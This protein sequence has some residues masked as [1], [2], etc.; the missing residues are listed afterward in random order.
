MSAG[1]TVGQTRDTSE[2]KTSQ[3]QPP[4]PAGE[5]GHY[6]TPGQLLTVG[7]ARSLSGGREAGVGVLVLRMPCLLQILRKNNE[8]FKD[9]FLGPPPSVA[10][11]LILPWELCLCLG[12]AGSCAR[13]TGREEESEA[14]KLPCP[15]SPQPSARGPDVQ[16]AWALAQPPPAHLRS[17]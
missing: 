6:Q 9:G 4:G 14:T 12:N 8:P 5:A 15:L 11:F 2:A 1:A 7:L 16:S 10:A 17:K 3:T 13:P